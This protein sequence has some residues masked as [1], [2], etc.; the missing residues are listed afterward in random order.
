MVMSNK[1]P[2][3]VV[4]DGNNDMR[5][6]IRSV[7]P[8]ATHRLCSWHLQQN[9]NENVKNP[10]FLEDFKRLIYDNFMPEEFE[11]R[12]NEVIEKYGLHDNNWANKIYRLKDLWA[13]AYLRDKLFC[14]IR[15]TS[16]CQGIN[17][18]IK[19]YVQQRNNL[20]D[21][22]HNFKRAVKEYRHIELMSD[23]KSSYGEP[24]LTTPL[25]KYENLND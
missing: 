13:R 17:S 14:G 21:F 19:R 20:V 8:D 12:W 5:E 1:Q 18:F 6:A 7:F 11:T 22:I 24:V 15:T 23:F 9:A 4:T 25:Y 10:T 3:V 16:I 2:K